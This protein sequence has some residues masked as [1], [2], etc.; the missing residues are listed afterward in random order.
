MRFSGAA[1]AVLGFD[2]SE[3]RESELKKDTD[4]SGRLDEMSSLQVSMVAFV[5]ANIARSFQLR[6]S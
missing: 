3:I 5:V 2:S 1:K 6:G 4:C